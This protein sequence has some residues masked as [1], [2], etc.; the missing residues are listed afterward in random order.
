MHELKSNNI[1]KGGI[2]M[3]SADAESLR[4]LENSVQDDLQAI[5][6]NQTRWILA[7]PDD[8]IACYQRLNKTAMQYE[9]GIVGSLHC[10]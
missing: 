9:K 2:E 5:D 3:T 8:E 4:L 7:S 1:D 6:S 10:I